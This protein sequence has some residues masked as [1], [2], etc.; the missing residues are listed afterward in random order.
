MAEF[1]HYGVRGQKWGVRRY[2]NKDGS[3]TAAGKKRYSDSSSS[4]K[5]STSKSTTLKKKMTSQ[6]KW[7]K[8]WENDPT[9]KRLSITDTQKQAANI[10]T[11]L[12]T[13]GMSGLTQDIHRQQ[14]AENFVSRFFT[15][16]DKYR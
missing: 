15:G 4:K 8:I 9:L 14:Q 12:A 13:R 1:M 16:E 6:E 11:T 2:E 5:V 10:I 7:D 3:L